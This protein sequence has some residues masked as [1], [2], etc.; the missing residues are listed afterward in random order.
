MN[1][2]IKKPCPNEKFT[3]DV[4]ADS[5]HCEF[6]DVEVVNFSRMTEYDARAH[7]KRGGCGTVVKRPDGQIIFRP[8]R[9]PK[10][11]HF[12]LTIAVIVASANGYAEL[13]SIAVSPQVA[14]EQTLSGKLSA[15]FEL[16]EV[17]AFD[18]FE[19]VGA[20][21]NPRFEERAV[22]SGVVF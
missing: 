3:P 21:E 22:M 5:T 8:R 18:V 17:Q 4:S 10:L 20:K 1:D 16:A 15:S 7:K 12:V 6:C 14:A 9:K 13:A 2:F 11:K 19:D